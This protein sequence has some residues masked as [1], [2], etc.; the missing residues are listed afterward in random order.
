VFDIN[1]FENKK[2]EVPA[3]LPTK[4]T[5][6]YFEIISEGY[7][8]YLDI[9]YLSGGFIMYKQITKLIAIMDGKNR[10]QET[11]EKYTYLMLKRLEQLK[12]IGSEYI[13]TNKFIYLRKPALILLTN[14]INTT[15][16]INLN[17]DLK[18]DKFKTS[19]LKVEYLIENNELIHHRTMFN[20]L[21][22]ITQTML[23]KIMNSGNKYNYNIDVINELIKQ[24]SYDDAF[25]LLELH[26]EYKYK[27]EVVREFWLHIGKLFSKLILQ[28]QTVTSYP[29]YGKCYVNA[30]GRVILHYVPTIIIFDVSH[31]ERYYREKCIKLF[32]DF[33]QMNLNNLRDIQKEYISSTGRSLGFIGENHIGYKL[34]LI[35]DD[36]K[37]LNVKKHVIDQNINSSNTSPLMGYADVIEVNTKHYFEHSSRK[38]NSVSNK[39]DKK[40]NEKIQ[41]NKVVSSE[42]DN[43]SINRDILK[44]VN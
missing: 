44:I 27:L 14:N 43:S 19:I 32:Y 3:E 40:I 23:N 16:R 21:I 26:E 13:N 38:N 42:R 9:I 17:K 33:T 31:D 41:I 11:N 39:Q 1:Y 35:G 15:Q 18:N 29:N 24:N 12:F 37:V 8:K 10:T 6:K 36:M 20:Q 2:Y 7:A 5:Y 34:L 4:S 22:A 30:D 28:R 25:R